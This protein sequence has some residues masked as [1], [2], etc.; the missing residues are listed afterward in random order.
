VTDA[1]GRYYLEHPFNDCLVEGNK[2]YS[3]YYL[4]LSTGLIALRASP[5]GSILFDESRCWVFDGIDVEVA[6]CRP[7]PTMP[8]YIHNRIA[9]YRNMHP[10]KRPHVYSRSYC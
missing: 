4:D 1:P 10:A 6:E 3:T 7:F 2:H 8:A 9:A 5:M